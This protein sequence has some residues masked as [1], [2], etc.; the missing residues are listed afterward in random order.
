MPWRVRDRREA[1][2]VLGKGEGEKGCVRAALAQRLLTS[3]G[4]KNQSNRLSAKT[5]GHT[6]GPAHVRTSRLLLCG[7]L[8]KLWR[9][10]I[11]WENRLARNVGFSLMTLGQSQK[12]LLSSERR[13]YTIG[14]SEIDIKSKSKRFTLIYHADQSPVLTIDVL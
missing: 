5:A 3:S 9:G 14:W 8:H 7:T 4:Q 10:H 1:R 13:D 11:Y 6:Q 12:V 2:P